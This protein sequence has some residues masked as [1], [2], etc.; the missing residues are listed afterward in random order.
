MIHELKTWSVFYNEVLSYK[1]RFE[2]RLDDRGFNTGDTLLLKEYDLSTEAYTGRSLKVNVLYIT[3]AYQ[4]HN[5]IVMSISEP[6]DIEDPNKVKKKT[7][8]RKSHK[9]GRVYAV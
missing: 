6:Y 5:Y 2:I 4:R 1:K 8:Y 7:L 9:N 3:D